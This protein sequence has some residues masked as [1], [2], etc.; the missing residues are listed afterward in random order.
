[1]NEVLQALADAVSAGSLYAIIALGIAL[2]FGV[3]RLVNMAYGETIVATAYAAYFLQDQPAWVLIP[4]MIVVGI[5]LS[6]LIERVAFRPLR[7]ASPTTMLIAAFAVGFILQNAALATVGASPRAIAAGSS[8]ATSQSIGPVNV[9]GYSIVTVLAV[10]VIVVVL[11]TF[12]MRTS[13]G[14]GMRAASEDFDAA[15]LI[16]VKA[17]SVIRVAFVLSGAIAGVVGY[18]LIAATGGITPTSGLAPALLGFIAVVV[19][20]MGS[21]GA[22]ALGG[23]LLGAVTQILQY[24]LPTDLL[25]FRDALLFAG[26]LLLLVWRPQGLF[27]RTSSVL[28]R[29]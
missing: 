20:G 2:I 22:A 18:L 1:M 13:L 17:N 4:G 9:P 14:I 6:V 29:A 19:G 12:L 28:D 3:M 25:V 27:I 21:L 5:G 15:R 26:V 8:L 11:R 24:L 23:F 7:S 10:V 16:G